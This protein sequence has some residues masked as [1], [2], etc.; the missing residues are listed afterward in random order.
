M[1]RDLKNLITRNAPTE[2]I[3]IEAIS[4]GMNVL[5]QE[6]IHA[7]FEGVTDVKQVMSTCLI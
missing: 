2:D 1:T 5:L 4:D 3:K 7:I 6:G